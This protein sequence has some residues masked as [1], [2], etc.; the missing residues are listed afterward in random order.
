[1]RNEGP[2]REGMGGSG[3]TGPHIHNLDNTWR[4]PWLFSTRGNK[5]GYPVIGSLV[6]LIAGLDILRRENILY[7]PRTE[8]RLLGYSAYSLVIEQTGCVYVW[9][10]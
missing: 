4:S 2:C 3:V 9:V 1:M 6:G 5:S 10:L 7:L 8:Q